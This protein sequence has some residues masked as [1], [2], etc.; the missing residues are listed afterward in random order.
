MSATQPTA[1]PGGNTPGARW[2]PFRVMMRQ[3]RAE[4]TPRVHPLPDHTPGGVL[5][6]GAYVV[7]VTRSTPAPAPITPARER[8]I[9]QPPGIY[10]GGRH[11]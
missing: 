1:T 11:I 4:R 6:L 5:N 3:L 7:S 8:V 9:P 10:R 2:S